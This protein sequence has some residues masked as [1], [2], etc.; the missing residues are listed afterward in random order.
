MIDEPAF[1]KSGPVYR[2]TNTI[3]VQWRATGPEVTLTDPAKYF[4]ITGHH[5]TVHAEFE[6]SVPSRGFHFRGHATSTTYA[7]IGSETNGYFYDRQI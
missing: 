7:F 3:H 1:P 4:S 2:A 5:A 6:V